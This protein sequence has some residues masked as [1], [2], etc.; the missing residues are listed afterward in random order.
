M[1]V[2]YGARV[3]FDNG[4]EVGSQAVLLAKFV[5]EGFERPRGVMEIAPAR[6][7][8]IFAIGVDGIEVIRLVKAISG[9]GSEF[10]PAAGAGACWLGKALEFFRDKL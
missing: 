5:G 9:F 6:F 4:L 10:E 8:G 1:R 7:Q 3:R 2:A